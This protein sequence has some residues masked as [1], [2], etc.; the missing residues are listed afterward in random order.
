MT[1]IDRHEI[2]VTIGG[3]PVTVLEAETTLDRGWAPYVQGTLT[4]LAPSIAGLLDPRTRPPVLVQHRRRYSDSRTVGEVSALHAGLTVGQVS[5]LYAGESV[6]EMSAQYRT[7]WNP[8]GPHGVAPGLRCAGWLTAARRSR[9]DPDVW[10]IRWAGDEVR[11]LGAIRTHQSTPAPGTTVRQLVADVLAAAGLGTLDPGGATA[12]ESA[13]D[14][15]GAQPEWEPGVSV[16][17]YLEPV[18]TAAGYRLYADERAVWR[19]VDDTTTTGACTI[20]PAAVEVEDDWDVDNGRFFD[21]AVIVYEWETAGGARRRT[22]DAY[23][24]GTI[25]GYVEHVNGR[26]TRRGRAKRIVQR[27]RSRALA[28]AWEQV[29]D[30]AIRP[31]QA[32]TLAPDGT[33]G[34]VDKVAY[35]YPAARS[36]VTVLDPTPT[37]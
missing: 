29:A 6:E 11:A 35:R 23:S 2:A 31:G 14:E 27:A 28:Q 34:L 9:T 22:V 13:A 16:W 37:T 36:A 18:V 8:G 24:T 15:D 25:S 4:I 21:T 20:G 1:L 7:S 10:E 17:E 26:M 3:Q 12:G 19:L 32:A 30:Y 5:S 33:T